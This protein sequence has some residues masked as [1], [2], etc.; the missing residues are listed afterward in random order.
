M[1]DNKGSIVDSSFHGFVAGADYVG[2]IA[3]SNNSQVKSCFTS[4]DCIG[5]LGVGGLI[6]TN[7]GSI[8]LSSS[9][10]N[11]VGYSYVGGLCGA[12][13]GDVSTSYSTGNVMGVYEI[14][15]GL[16]GVNYGVISNSYSVSSVSG[17]RIT[18]GLAGLHTG[19]INNCYSA[20]LTTDVKGMVGTIYSYNNPTGEVN[21]SFWDINKANQDIADANNYGAIG[22]TSAELQDI[23]IFI[24]AGWDFQGENGNG[25]DD[26]WIM[27]GYPVFAFQAD[28][29]LMPNIMNLNLSEAEGTLADNGFMVG[30]V[31]Y[32]YSDIIPENLVVT[33]SYPANSAVA[34]GSLVDV[35]LSLGTTHTLAGSG[36]ESMPYL[37]NGIN[38]F[39]VFIDPDNASLYWAE[40]KYV[41]LVNDIDLDRQVFNTA[42]VAPDNDKR[43]SF[44][45]G[46]AFN[47]DFDG[48]GHVIKNLVIDTD[49]LDNDYLGFFGEIGS[50][51]VVHDLG[52][53]K[54]TIN[55][56]VRSYNIGSICGKN[57]GGNISNCYSTGKINCIEGSDYVGGLCGVNINGVMN[58]CFSTVSIDGEINSNAVGGFCGENYLGTITNSYATGNI[59]GLNNLGG[60]CGIN[61]DGI[62]ENCYTTGSINALIDSSSLGGFCG[63]NDYS[64]I[65]AC[66]STGVVNAPNGSKSVGGFCGDSYESMIESCFWD[67]DTSE[68]NI[69]AGGTGCS[70]EQIQNVNTFVDAGWNI[71]ESGTDK[72]LIIDGSSPL[73]S[74]QQG[75][76]AS[77]NLKVFLNQNS[78]GTIEFSITNVAN[79]AISWSISSDSSCTWI[80]SIT[81]DSGTL[82]N[83]GS[84]QAINI[85]VD[86]NDL[87]VGTH[88]VELIALQESGPDV[89]IPLTLNVTDIVDMQNFAALSNYW[90][91]TECNQT[92]PCYDADWNKDTIVDTIDL[93]DLAEQWLKE[94]VIDNSYEEDFEGSDLESAGYKLSANS[95]WVISPQNE[96]HSNAITTP[97]RYYNHSEIS[98][99]LN[100]TGCTYISFD[101]YKQFTFSYDENDVAVLEFY[102]DG[103]VQDR[104]VGFQLIN[105]H[106]YPIVD[107]THIFMWKYYASYFEDHFGDSFWID[108]IRIQ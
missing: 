98:I 74:W 55:A 36:T 86:S 33:Q 62:I 63:Y 64:G 61:S 41:K 106:A 47:A 31:R 105:N 34:A 30:N 99:T 87:P 83:F 81:P 77:A 12:S 54:L 2:G 24:N 46:T 4:G 57:N 7:Y 32:D 13:G 18:G 80:K 96:F 101:M 39:Y 71:S 3:G 1:Q 97:A 82:G 85:N 22:K 60:F 48:D 67:I 5:E 16:V 103:V 65:Y 52:I 88:T 28:F 107:G 100:T 89:L 72:W 70:T 29:G 40:G 42:L 75:I 44:F 94:K 38:D 20:G 43:K 23:N 27:N 51:A 102:I 79:N 17:E 56:G 108:N 93:V 8:S 92:L 84:S 58:N 78:K 66:Y 11:V 49:M 68:L 14:I 9:S 10:T 37:I 45:Q 59:I 15:G 6:G 26:I 25:I 91:T 73:L 104:W 53:E 95:A 90:L 76:V 50:T 19:E 69:S 21:N 35:V